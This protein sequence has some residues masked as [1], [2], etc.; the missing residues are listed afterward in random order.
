MFKETISVYKS[1]LKGNIFYQNI[2]LVASGNITA[3]L[4]VIL[5]T[6]IITRLYTPD[7]YGIYSVF[8]SIIGITGSLATLRYSVTIP[9]ANNEKLADNLLRLCFIV[10]LSLSLIWLLI[11]LLFKDIIT[12]YYHN[13][14]IKSFL[15]FIPIVFFGQGIYEALNN[16]AV[17]RRNFKLITRT[18]ISQG[19][20]S[21]V[22]KIGFGFFK[23]TP[24]GLFVG[25][26]AQEVAGIS[27]II[28]TLRKSNPFFFRYFNWQDIIDAANR[29]KKFP[30]VQSWS[31]LLLSLGA[32]LPVLLIG[33]FY[34]STVV[35]VFGL[36]MGMINLPMD[37]IGQAVSQV[38]YAEISR[39]GKN[40][41]EKIFKLS[42][43]LIKKLFLIGLFPVLII[44]LFGPFLFEFVFGEEWHDAGIFARYFSMIILT[45]FISS[46][47]TNIFNVLEKQGI[48]MTLNLVRVG[49]VALIFLFSNIVNLNANNAVLLYG[50]IFP[51]YSIFGLFITLRTLKVNYKR[52]F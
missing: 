48:Q 20:S 3:K 13:D 46:P 37:L 11:I 39:I 34:G 26:F 29:Y 8:I 4:I 49:L 10:T 44:F 30:L 47:I 35:G 22:I 38:Y 43:S 42:I 9:L 15:W 2:A 12:D 1:R 33:A 31:Q 28:L 17:R 52:A 6:P 51:L 50:I 45:R 24:L 25:H 18:K 36:A 7:E 14:N 27:S 41:P 5:T 40:F 19:I 21:T 32:Q 16:W 23:I